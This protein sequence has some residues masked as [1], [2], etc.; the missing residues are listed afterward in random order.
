MLKYIIGNDGNLCTTDLCVNETGIAVCH[1]DLITCNGTR[2][3][4]PLSCDTSDGVCK[5]AEITCNDNNKVKKIFPRFI[6][7]AP[8]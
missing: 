8:R 1:N 7:R 4:Y 2:P 5:G 3:C 6:Y